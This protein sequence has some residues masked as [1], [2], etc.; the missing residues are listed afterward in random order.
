MLF[1]SFVSTDIADK[2][3]YVSLTP[4]YIRDAAIAVVG[5]DVSQSDTL[6]VCKSWID[7]VKDTAGERCLI[8]GV[9]NKIDLPRAVSREQAVSFF[10]GCGVPAS[11]YFETSAKTG[12]GVEK[13]LVNSLRLWRDANKDH[14]DGSNVLILRGVFIGASGIGAKTSL[15]LRIANNMFEE[16]LPTTISGAFFSR[17][18]NVDGVQY[19]LEMWGLYHSVFSFLSFNFLKFLLFNRYCWSRTVLGF[20]TIVLKRFRFSCCWI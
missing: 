6:D 18:F 7:L 8:I 5:Y 15:L 9:G 10:E 19:K 13:F 11:H 14:K 1:F 2:E 12:E 20:D 17:K 3:R 4:L 16:F